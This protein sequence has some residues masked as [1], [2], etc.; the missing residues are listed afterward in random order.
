MITRRLFYL[1]PLS[2]YAKTTWIVDDLKHYISLWHNK[3]IPL[4]N[5]EKTRHEFYIY[6]CE[7]LIDAKTKKRI[8][9]Y[10]VICNTKNNPS[11]EEFVAIIFIWSNTGNYVRLD[12]S[13]INDKIK[14]E[15]D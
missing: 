12:L 4:N 2:L 13:I 14:F 3:N 15:I 9:N 11:P 7:I 8:K 1:I 6:I 5:T 10:R